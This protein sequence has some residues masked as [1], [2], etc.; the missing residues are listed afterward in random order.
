MEIIDW[1]LK[2]VNSENR[3]EGTHVRGKQHLPWENFYYDAAF[4]LVPNVST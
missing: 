1:R 3:L 4:D 2:E